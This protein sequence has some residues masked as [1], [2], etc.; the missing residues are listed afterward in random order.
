MAH[1]AQL[2]A[3]NG[4]RVLGIF[5]QNF[6]FFCLEQAQGL[7]N[8]GIPGGYLLTTSYRQRLCSAKI[9]F[10]ILGQFKFLGCV[11]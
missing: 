4:D 2:L 1:P 11:S 8:K 10:F 3:H 7:K 6:W 9:I 5:M